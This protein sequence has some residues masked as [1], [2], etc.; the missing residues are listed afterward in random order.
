MDLDTMIALMA[1]SLYK[2]PRSTAVTEQEATAS[3]VKT[4]RLIWSEVLK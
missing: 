2:A 4:A 3:A 1:S